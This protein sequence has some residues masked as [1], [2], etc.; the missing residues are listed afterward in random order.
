MIFKIF[1]GISHYRKFR[2]GILYRV[3]FCDFSSKLGSKIFLKFL[4]IKP[5]FTFGRFL[6]TKLGPLDSRHLYAEQ[7]PGNKNV[8]QLFIQHVI[9]LIRSPIITDRNKPKTCNITHEAVFLLV[10]HYSC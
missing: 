6:K 4:R 5:N 8:T 2:F 1:N 9:R 3:N 7:P 10:M